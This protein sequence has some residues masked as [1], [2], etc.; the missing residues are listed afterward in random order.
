MAETKRP[1]KQH[2][3]VTAEGDTVTHSVQ[4]ARPTG[5][6][7]PR[8]IFAFVCWAVAIAFELVALFLFNGTLT[9]PFLPIPTLWQIIGAIV[10]DLIF[11][12]IGSMLWKKAN[13]IKPASKRNKTLFWLWNNMGLIAAVAC[14]LPLIVLILTNK[15]ADGKSK[16]IAAI[17]AVV[18]LL[19]GGIGSYDFDP[20]S[21]EEQGLAVNAYGD[22]LVYWS[23]YGKVYHSHEDCYHLNKSDTL[24]QGTVDQAIAAN[25]TKLCSNCLSLDQ[26]AGMDLEGVLTE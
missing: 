7:T 4:T 26:E 2:T 6:A 17:V 3:I 5:S 14:F 19:I 24:T 12:L 11:L 25:R 22:A 15:D 9:L 8:R 16:K 10:L 13:H 23:P 20:I 1:R 18:A 21:A